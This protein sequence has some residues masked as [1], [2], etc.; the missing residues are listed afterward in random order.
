MITHYETKQLEKRITFK[1]NNQISSLIVTADSGRIIYRKKI[2]T[3]IGVN[4]PGLILGEDLWGNVWVIHNHYKHGT[5][6]VESL[7]DFSIGQP[8]WFDSRP[9]F[10]NRFE[11]LNRAFDHWEAKKKYHWLVNNCEHFVNRIA[12]NKH[13]SETVD[14]VSNFLMILGGLMALIGI[15]SGKRTFVKLGVGISGGALLGKGLSKLQ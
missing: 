1:S 3:I 13:M 14:K 12:R 6:V 7:K 8:W 4:H 5:T 10:Y 11:V 2:D 9:Q 15:I